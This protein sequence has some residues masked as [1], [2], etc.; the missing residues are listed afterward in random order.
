M[1][2]SNQAQRV[3]IPH[4]P[5]EWMEI[6]KL[7]WRQLVL[8]ADIQTDET[9]SRLKK[10]GGDLF[11]SLTTEKAKQETDSSLKYDRGFVLEAGICRWSYDADVNKEN[12]ENLDEQTAKWAF[13]AITG[14]NKPL[15]D[16]ERKN[17]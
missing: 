8:A 15:T 6:K 13:D 14:L 7:S 10:I 2:I 11:K 12:I 16:E 17:A 5:G 1:L 9:I 3:D 4:E